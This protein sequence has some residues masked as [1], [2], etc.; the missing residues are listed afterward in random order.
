MDWEKNLLFVRNNLKVPL[1]PD[2]ISSNSAMFPV[3]SN[4]KVSLK[5]SLLHSKQG[6]NI[7][8]DN[9]AFTIDIY[10]YM[11]VESYSIT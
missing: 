8:T 4:S 2:N 1:K 7:Q 11:Y 6:A 10:I 5:L 3:K 9:E